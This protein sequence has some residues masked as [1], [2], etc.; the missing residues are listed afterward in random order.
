MEQKE[1][2][3]KTLEEFVNPAERP[4]ESGV[5]GNYASIVDVPN[6]PNYVYVRLSSGLM[7]EAYNNLVPS[8]LNLN[9]LVGTNPQRPSELKVLDVL[10]GLHPDGIGTPMIS[11]HGVSHEWPGADTVYMGYRQILPL[12]TNVVSATE[13]SIYPGW[14]I[15][16]DREIKYYPGTTS[17]I[18]MTS[19]KPTTG[20]RWSLLSV[21]GS[22]TV[23]VTDGDAKGYFELSAIDI[24][25]VP[26]DE[27][28]LSAI[29]T[30][31]GQVT[32]NDNAL[33]STDIIDLRF[34]PQ[35]SSNTIRFDDLRIEPIARTTGV[36]A[37]TFE[38]WL[39]A[40]GTSRGVYL[41]SF[42]DAIEASEKEI[43]YTIQLPHSWNEGSPINFH[44]HWIGN[45]ADTTAKPLWGLE[46]VWK[47]IGQVYGYTKLVYSTSSNIDGDGVVDNDITA[48][49]HYISSF[50]PITPDAAQNGI[51]SVIICRLFR[52]SSSA[53]DTYNAASNKC[54]LLYA[55]VHIE[56]DGI[57]SRQEYTK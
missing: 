7:V 2:L 42:D 36:N 15:N 12:R 8:F 31:A 45:V 14:Y 5:L 10:L 51:S 29:R 38:K 13:V 35:S 17:N 52:N 49:R 21:D 34:V 28:A 56:V 9:V 50:D 43:F 33:A 22:G 55:D 57:G 19:H 37:P 18:S 16:G 23:S 46:Y 24:P 53:S 39:D 4:A 11:K 40:S 32:I 47:D 3:Y 48:N 54:G 25:V 27:I 44:V 26:E 20:A 30:F 1:K 6:R 41:Y